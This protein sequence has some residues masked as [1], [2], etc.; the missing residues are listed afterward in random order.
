MRRRPRGESETRGVLLLLFPKELWNRPEE[1]KHTE[2][3]RR[4]CLTRMTPMCASKIKI[5]RVKFRGV[6]LHIDVDQIEL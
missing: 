3:E 6:H 4:Q 1:K 2:G 5:G